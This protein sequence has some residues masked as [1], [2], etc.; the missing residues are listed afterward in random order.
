MKFQI[1]IPIIPDYI[2]ISLL[3]QQ[4]KNTL[5]FHTKVAKLHLFSN[6]NR[7]QYWLVEIPDWIYY[8]SSLRKFDRRFSCSFYDIL[9]HYLNLVHFEQKIT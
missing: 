3:Q 2:N 6:H 8:S 1:E 7:K 5:Y 4:Q 9:A